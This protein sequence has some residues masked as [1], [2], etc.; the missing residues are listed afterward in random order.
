MEKAVEIYFYCDEMQKALDEIKRNVD[1]INEALGNN[2]ETD[3]RNK[4]IAA[5]ID[6]VASKCL[7]LHYLSID[8]LTEVQNDA[9][10][11]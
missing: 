8:A 4:R 5:Q 10:T 3:F 7:K 6:N 2:P 9:E 11:V 1:F